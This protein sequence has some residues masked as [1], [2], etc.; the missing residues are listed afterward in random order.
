MLSSDASC[1]ANTDW[2]SFKINNIITTLDGKITLIEG[3]NSKSKEKE[4]RI[5]S[6]T[7]LRAAY[8]KA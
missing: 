4:I 8:R 6:I 7:T 1:L 5:L 3:Y 2:Q